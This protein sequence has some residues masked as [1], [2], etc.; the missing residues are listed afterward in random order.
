[1][2]TNANASSL[3]E[4][5][6]ADGFD[7]TV[8]LLVEAIESAGL[9]VIARLDHSGGARKAGLDLPPT[10]VLVYG[11]PKGGT[12]IMQAHPTAALELP[13]RVLILQNA[14]GR[15]VVSFHPVVAML[16]PHGVP[17]EM[18]QRLEPAQALIRRALRG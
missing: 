9:M 18:A 8:A 15:I 16:A 2:S 14:D 12:P 13:L 3:I 10:L 7:E 4:L 11:H 1:M 5:V 17:Q 6:S